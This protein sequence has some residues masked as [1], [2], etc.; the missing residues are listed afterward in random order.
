MND[1]N[2]NKANLFITTDDAISF[3][4]E[5]N[6]MLDCDE[7]EAIVQ[8]SIRN[9]I[10][11]CF[12]Y[13]NEKLI[14]REDF[15]NKVNFLILNCNRITKYNFFDVSY[16]NLIQV[17][18][19]FAEHTYAKVNEEEL[20]YNEYAML[21]NLVDLCR[22][23]YV[24]DN[25]D[26]VVYDF[27][28][29]RIHTRSKTVNIFLRQHKNDLNHLYD[30]KG[31]YFANTAHYM[32][33][34]KKLAPF[35]ISAISYNNQECAP[36]LDIMCGSGAASNAFSQFWNV[37]S[38]DA[39]QFCTILATIQGKNDGHNSS[40]KLTEKIVE[41]YN[42][43]YTELYKLFGSEI[44]KEIELFKNDYFTMHHI[45]NAER[46]NQIG[47]YK[48]EQNEV[49]AMYNN[50]LYMKYTSF[51]VNTP[52]YQSNQNLQ[53]QSYNEN[54][55]FLIQERKGNPA[56]FPYCLFTLYYSNIYFG[57]LQS[58]QI[59]S[60]RYAIDKLNDK[61][62]RIWALGALIV[63]CSVSA[64]S[65]GGHFAQPLKITAKNID[66]VINI[67]KRSILRE[68]IKRLMVIL[69]EGKKSP[70]TISR[71][72]GPW[73]KTLDSQE[74]RMFK[75]LIVYLDAPYKREEYSRYYHVLET[76][77]Q[78]NYPS[79][80]GIGK[81]SSKKKGERFSSE[82]FT[83]SQNKVNSIFVEII[84]TVLNKGWKCVWSYSDNGVASMIHVI[85]NVYNNTKCKIN[86]YHMPYQ[87]K[88]HGRTIKTNSR[89]MVTE[90]I[91]IF[92]NNKMK[93]V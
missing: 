31:S 28:G 77:V 12:I 33:N 76:L 20:S 71:I 58:V 26:E 49:N 39:L 85:E 53:N 60:L 14:F 10:L 43:N 55:D 62:D 88:V 86:I 3:I 93:E 69:D 1:D 90:Y 17:P 38:S 91:I 82:F 11:A 73:Q 61:D 7:I 48:E 89:K 59:D 25:I 6:D 45:K 83:H 37:I 27:A 18:I 40:Q 50:D 68:F 21:N 4:V 70:H 36:I 9:G 65:Y 41:N 66:K 8:F 54:Y 67:R 22:K 51:I 56:I 30:S 2:V 87:H 23:G 16:D 29:V 80:E 47:K 92:Q 57:V 79:S 24:R 64:T 35:L 42:K 13:N 81:M 72:N 19:F 34:K 74:L 75:D 46:E 63:A 44:E 84:I 52:L 15:L 78:Y 5:N 32:G